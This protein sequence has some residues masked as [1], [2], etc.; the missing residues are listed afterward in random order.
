MFNWWY[1]IETYIS[2][3]SEGKDYKWLQTL[4]VKY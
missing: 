3:K 1:E 2:N 4:S